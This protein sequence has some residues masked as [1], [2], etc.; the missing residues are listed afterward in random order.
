MLLSRCI[1][2]LSGDHP[3]HTGAALPG[4]PLCALCPDS[5]A[6][7]QRAAHYNKQP[8]KLL[9]EVAYGS[10]V[11]KKSAIGLEDVAGN[12]VMGQEVEQLGDDLLSCLEAADKGS[13][14]GEE[15]AMDF[16]MR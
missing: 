11:G 3:V 7:L 8:D 10:K 6:V 15:L 5:C 14:L 1:N 13:G 16:G 2:V 9:A 4:W 12:H